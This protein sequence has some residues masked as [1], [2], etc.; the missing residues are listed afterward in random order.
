VYER[1]RDKR[2]GSRASARTASLVLWYCTLLPR[3]DL[4]SSTSGPLTSVPP[5]VQEHK[6]V[7][8]S[9]LAV[10][11]LHHPSCRMDMGRT[12]TP[13]TGC[14]T[15]SKGWDVEVRNVA[16]FAPL[17][18]RERGAVGL[19][20]EGGS[21]PLP[22]QRRNSLFTFCIELLTVHSVERAPLCQS[23]AFESPITMRCF[24]RECTC[25]SSVNWK[26]PHRGH[27]LRRSWAGAEISE[28]II[29]SPP[30]TA[31]SQVRPQHAPPNLRDPARLRRPRCLPPPHA[32]AA[33]HLLL[34]PLALDHRLRS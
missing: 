23:I 19:A 17:E 25:L 21:R 6:S 3:P 2:I 34:R 31:A 4:A 10:C 8:R 27:R 29:A 13:R 11:S 28:L 12:V 26:K 18:L 33:L 32:R 24:Q 30:A 14:E 20:A 7:Y 15:C 5:R 16:L 22:V 1:V 9:L